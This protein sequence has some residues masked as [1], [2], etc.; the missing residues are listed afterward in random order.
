M[1][2]AQAIRGAKAGRQDAFTF[3]YTKHRRMVYAVCLRAAHNHADA[4]DLTQD[5]F[6]RVME[7][8]QD[9]RG[10]ADF[11]TWVFRIAQNET[12]SLHRR[13]NYRQRGE[14]MRRVSS[15][16]VDLEVAA[17]AAPTDL[18]VDLERALHQVNWNWVQWESY[19]AYLAG[20]ST[21]EIARYTYST[22]VGVN[23]RLTGMRAELRQLMH[24]E[25]TQ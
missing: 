4:E 6:L 2:E 10:Q 25:R 20:Y 11:K 8:I 24:R 15:D 19:L 23:K 9:F 22:P 14:V 7:K 12:H 3:L 17:P 21:K 18:E 13:R 16:V 1:T 5:V